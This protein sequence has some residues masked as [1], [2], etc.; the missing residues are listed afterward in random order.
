[1]PD[2]PL[3]IMMQTYG[4]GIRPG[5]KLGHWTVLGPDAAAVRAAATGMLRALEARVEP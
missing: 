5:R 4:K 2:A 1:M 3:R